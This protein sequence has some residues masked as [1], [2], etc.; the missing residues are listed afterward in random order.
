MR[1]RLGS[2]VERAAVLA[3]VSLVAAAPLRNARLGGGLGAL[4]D[5][6]LLAETLRGPIGVSSLVTATALLVLA[7]MA[8]R[9]GVGRVLDSLGVLAGIIALAGFALEGHT[10]SQQPRWLIVSLDVVHLMAAAVWIGGI[11]ALVVAFRAQLRPEALGRLVVRFSGAAVVTVVVVVLAGVGMAWI[12]LPSLGDLVGTGYG[13]ALLT[14]ALLVLP[15]VALG[16]Y[17]RRRLV[18]AMSAGAAAP[19]DRRSRL[20]RIVTIELVLLLAVVGVTSVLVTRS[21]I[22]S[23]ATPPPATV[24]PSDAVEVPLSNGAGTV[25]YAVA[26]ARAGQNEISLV[27]AGPDGQ[28]LVPFETPTVELTEPAL[29]VGPLRPLVHPLTDGQYHV[30]ADIPIAGEYTMVVRVRTSEF[31]AATAEATVAIS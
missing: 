8:G 23:S 4:R 25:R 21:P 7:G 28:P 5:N 10:R 1:R 11:A 20:G 29:G 2:L 24:V 14:K 31:E 27:L 16:A 12:V 19:S 3:S 30:I 6:D 17:N 18:P 22:A 15:V 26:P 13:R 9:E